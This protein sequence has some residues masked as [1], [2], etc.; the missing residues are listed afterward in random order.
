MARIYSLASWPHSWGRRSRAVGRGLVRLGLVGSV[1]CGRVRAV[2]YGFISDLFLLAS[3]VGYVVGS[4]LDR[5]V[6]S[7]E[8]ASGAYGTDFSWPHSRGRRLSPVS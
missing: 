8:V 4:G 2:R 5:M 7:A 6:G 1:R 3:F